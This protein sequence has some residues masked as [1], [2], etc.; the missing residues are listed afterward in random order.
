MNI[1]V[2]LYPLTQKSGL[3]LNLLDERDAKPI[4]YKRVNEETGEEV[5]WEHIVKGYKID[6]GEY[7]VL[8]KDELSDIAPESSEAIEIDTVVDLE[9]IPPTFID[10]P[11]VVEPGS[12][13]DKPYALLRQALRNLKK[14]GISQ[15][16]IR[17]RE[18]LSALVPH[19][20]ALLLLILRYENQLKKIDSYNIPADAKELGL[21]KKDVDMATQ[22]LKSM[23]GEWQPSEFSD[24]YHEALQKLVDEKASKKPRKS[25]AAA[26]KKSTTD[27]EIVDLADL[28]QQ[29]IEEEK[30][31]KKA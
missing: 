27:P 20:D 31:S 4:S 9:T 1:P 3:D 21:R 22:L 17:S 26:K 25:K 23:E 14:A 13:G 10:R 8:T 12:K 30:K 15:V 18:Y 2:Q 24:H 29:S 19:G 11:Y 7:V 5:P 28:L 6:G 16:A